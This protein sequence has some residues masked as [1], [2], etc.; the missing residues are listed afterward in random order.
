MSTPLV[1]AIAISKKADLDRLSKHVNAAQFTVNQ[2]SAIVTAL[3]SKSDQLQGF[4]AEAENNKST[5]LA[6]WNLAKDAL[7]AVKNQAETIDL[8][9][10]QTDTALDATR[11]LAQEMTLLVRKLVFCAELVDQLSQLANK[12]KS[13][14]PLIPDTLIAY[15]D[16]AAA[17]ANKAM[18]ATLTALQSCFAA[19]A[20]MADAKNMMDLSGEQADALQEKMQQQ[21]TERDATRFIDG[22]GPDSTGILALLRQRYEHAQAHYQHALNASEGVTAELEHARKQLA[23][24]KTNLASLQAGLGAANAVAYAA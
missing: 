22:E 8:A 16:K 4:L 2:L 7:S 5:A 19:S 11:T 12:Q 21:A 18:A 15:L 17:N 9:Q 10:G 6:D 1:K 3:T 14:N 13:S 20:T 23:R 24:A